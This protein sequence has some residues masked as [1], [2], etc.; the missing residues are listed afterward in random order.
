[1]ST[2]RGHCVRRLN[3]QLL[4]L[5]SLAV[6]K[7]RHTASLVHGCSVCPHSDCKDN[8]GIYAA[9]KLENKYNISEH[10]DIKGVSRASR[11]IHV[12]LY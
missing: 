10:F 3:K 11:E 4:F 9:L 7:G 1:M 2:V 12:A 8:K 6:D 5:L